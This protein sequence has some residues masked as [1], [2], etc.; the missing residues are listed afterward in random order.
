MWLPGADE[1]DE[2]KIANHR[3]VQCKID[4]YH[5]NLSQI[6]SLFLFSP[7]FSDMAFCRRDD[8]DGGGF[9]GSSFDRLGEI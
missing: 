9:D 1:A 5:C 6:N 2:A 4:D 7:L 8:I 3:R